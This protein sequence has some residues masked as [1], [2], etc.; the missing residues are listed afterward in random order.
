[1]YGVESTLYSLLPELLTAKA[2]VNPYISQ[3]SPIFEEALQKGYLI[4]RTNGQVW[5]WDL[6]QPGLSIFDVTNPAAREW[7][8]A[9]L[10]KLL[11]LGVDC[12]KACPHLAQQE[13]SLL[14]R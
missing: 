7:Y 1:V 10:H 2:I 5:Q 4:K 9:K 6:W 12:F 14:M 8:S 3:H 11:D 13:H